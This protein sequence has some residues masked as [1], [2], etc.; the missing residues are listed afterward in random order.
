MDSRLEKRFIS[1]G[2]K[3]CINEG[4]VLRNN[5]F[6]RG[7]VVIQTSPSTGIYV[8]GRYDNDK[9]V[10]E[11]HFPFVVGQCIIENEELVIERHLDKES[12]AVICDELKTGVTIIFYLQNVMDYLNYLSDD[13]NLNRYTCSLDRGSAIAKI[14]IKNKNVSL[15]AIS[16][17]GKILLPIVKNDEKTE[18]KKEAE[19]IKRRLISAAKNGDQD[20]IENLTMSD[21]DLYTRISSRIRNEDLFSIV[22]S[23]FMPC[24]V[25]CDQYSVVGEILDFY[26]EENT[27]SKEE[28]YIMT[29]DCNDMVFTMVI[30]KEDLLGEPAV[31]RRFKGQVWL[32]GSVKFKG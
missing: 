18:Q 13:L 4:F 31:G 9:F 28:I 14:P 15:T 25:E 12:Y 11:Y 26:E 20:A 16:V 8:F 17:S 19:R 3:R 10:Y 32:Q 21:I 2:V 29:L 1:S 22:D 24:G 7:V 23:T 27:F 6:D 30:N 5:T